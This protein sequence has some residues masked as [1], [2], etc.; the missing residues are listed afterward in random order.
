M[1]LRCQQGQD[2]SASA[3]HVSFEVRESSPWLGK[4]E[5]GGYERVCGFLSFE[6]ETCFPRAASS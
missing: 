1:A 2:F 3:Y 6:E 4:A 5:H